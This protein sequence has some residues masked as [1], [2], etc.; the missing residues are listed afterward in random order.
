MALAKALK[1]KGKA[2]KL[3][4]SRARKPPPAKLESYILQKIVVPSM[5]SFPRP[6]TPV[7]PAYQAKILI[8]TAI[9]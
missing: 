2:R 7:E 4:E 6:A 9:K 8:P 5:R 1:P 3:C